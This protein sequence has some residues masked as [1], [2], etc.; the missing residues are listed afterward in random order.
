MKQLKQLMEQ[1]KND[2][3]SL[4][5]KIEIDIIEKYASNTRI[6]IISVTGNNS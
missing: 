1:I 2:W 5:D 4:K 6:S 3:N